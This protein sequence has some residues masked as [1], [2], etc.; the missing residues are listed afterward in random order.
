MVLDFAGIVIHISKNPELFADK[1]TK[2]RTFKIFLS[3]T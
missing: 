3:R 2:I 1:K